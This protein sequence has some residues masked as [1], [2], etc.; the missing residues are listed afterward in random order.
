M[1]NSLI[2]GLG[3]AVSFVILTSAPALALTGVQATP[4]STTATTVSGPPRFEMPWAT[5]VFQ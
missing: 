1:R 4:V 3:A 2:L 5:G